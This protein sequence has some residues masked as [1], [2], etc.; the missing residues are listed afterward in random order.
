MRRIAVLLVILMLS[1][2]PAS[3]NSVVNLSTDKDI[4][5]SST[6]V[7]CSNQTHGGGSFFVDNTTGNDSWP[8]TYECPKG[9]IQSAVDIVAE[10]GTVIVREGV[11]YETVTL[12][13]QG[14]RLKVAEGERAILDG[15][16]SVTDDLG[17]FG[18][19]TIPA[20]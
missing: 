19:S 3:M 18:K 20:H 4:L 16:R 15:S 10:N 12:G 7:N 13:K 1:A 11:Y 9:T 17:V 8:G 2:V 5:Q 6:S 14:I